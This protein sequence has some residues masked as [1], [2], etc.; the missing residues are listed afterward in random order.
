MPKEKF[1]NALGR[2]ID[3]SGMTSKEVAAIVGITESQLSKYK[4]CKVIPRLFRL[5][6]L[7]CVLRL[8]YPRA[9]YLFELAGYKLNDSDLHSFIK[10]L[11]LE[12]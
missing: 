6:E 12:I 7:C 1:G 3:E 9:E 10:M 4:C 5:A 8:K 2:Y 11:L